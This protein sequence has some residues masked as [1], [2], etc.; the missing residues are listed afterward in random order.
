MSKWKYVFLIAGIIHYLG[1]LFF[2]IFASGE[3][4]EWANPIGESDFHMYLS[5]HTNERN[6]KKLSN[7][8]GS[9]NL[10]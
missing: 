8:P 9:K 1:I 3:K 2:G 5:A 6:K 10:D 7:V 4:Q